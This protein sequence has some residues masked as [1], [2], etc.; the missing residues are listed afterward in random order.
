MTHL[1]AGQVFW[2]A[3]NYI[4]GAN[5]LI[6]T[7]IGGAESNADTDAISPTHD[8]GVWQINYHAWSFLFKRLYWRDPVQNAQMA[9]WVFNETPGGYT[10]WSTYNSGA[11]QNWLG[12]ASQGMHNPR[13]VTGI[14]SSSAGGH[15][16]ELTLGGRDVEG[17]I[18]A[19]AHQLWTGGDD[20]HSS[21]MA[22]RKHRLYGR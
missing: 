3:D 13:K 5:S 17:L 7:A 8:Y 18:R 19:S 16:G 22:I 2:L 12:W 20:M 14:S 9:S 4:G 11:Y 1:S 10:A 6:M 15:S 21:A